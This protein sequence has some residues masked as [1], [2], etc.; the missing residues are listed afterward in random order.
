PGTVPEVGDA[1]PR[2]VEDLRRVL[3]Q[4]RGSRRAARHRP[5]GCGRRLEAAA[6]DV[7]LEVVALDHAERC[8]ERLRGLPAGEGG[9]GGVAWAPRRGPDEAERPEHEC[10][11]PRHS[12]QRYAPSK[13]LSIE[14][15]IIWQ[16]AHHSP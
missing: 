3:V 15:V 11:A 8:V 14:N 7:D 10:C 12:G 9:E 6:D 1:A 13:E 2:R 5:P 4:H 16:T